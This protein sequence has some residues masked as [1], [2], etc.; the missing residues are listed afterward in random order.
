MPA[1]HLEDGP[2]IIENEEDEF[3]KLE[4]IVDGQSQNSLNEGEEDEDCDIV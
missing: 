1:K 2:K 3:P 4:V